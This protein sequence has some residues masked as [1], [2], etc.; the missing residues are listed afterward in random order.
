[1]DCIT[2]PGGC[3]LMAQTTTEYTPE[4]LVGVPQYSDGVMPHVYLAVNGDEGWTIADQWA[5]YKGSELPEPSPDPAQEELG[6]T[7]NQWVMLQHQTRALALS[8]IF[9]DLD[10]PLTELTAEEW[11]NYLYARSESWFGLAEDGRTEIPAGTIFRADFTDRISSE[12]PTP[13]ALENTEEPL[14]APCAAC[15]EIKTLLDADPQA[16]A[17]S[18]TGDVVTA[19]LTLPL[20]SGTV[21]MEYTFGLVPDDPAPFSRTYLQ[22]AHRA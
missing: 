9:R 17:Y 6:L 1:M 15:E 5:Y 19:T 20:E 8:G 13:A 11:A 4:A 14:P 12:D 16:I 7:R 22:S 18:R 10:D 21:A 2:D 3:L